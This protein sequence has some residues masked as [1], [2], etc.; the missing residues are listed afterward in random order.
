MKHR[1]ERKKCLNSAMSLRAIVLNSCRFND[2]N[3][4]YKKHKKE[5]TAPRE[6]Q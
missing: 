5:A 4:V 2:K 1:F 6:A 3:I